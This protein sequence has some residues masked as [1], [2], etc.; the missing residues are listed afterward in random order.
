MEIAAGFIAL[1]RKNRGIIAFGGGTQARVVDSE[2][3]PSTEYEYFAAN[4]ALTC[5][6]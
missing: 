6:L 1:I 5:E 4:D 3:D 2:L